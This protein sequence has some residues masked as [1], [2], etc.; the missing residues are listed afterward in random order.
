MKLVY[1]KELKEFKREAI[2]FY[3][4]ILYDK[5]K[6]I[7]ISDKEEIKKNIDNE[8]FELLLYTGRTDRLFNKIYE[9]DIIEIEGLD[10]CFWLVSF[11]INENTGG[12][13]SLV[14]ITSSNIDMS[15]KNLTLNNFKRDSLLK[16]KRYKNI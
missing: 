15:K 13:F 4:I 14:E 9:G 3:D 16:L 1:K 5:K 6:D 8:N 10:N 7:L 12:D 2:S 11:N